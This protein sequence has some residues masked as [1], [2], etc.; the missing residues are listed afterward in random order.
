[1]VL[2][3]LESF[4]PDEILVPLLSWDHDLLCIP[5]WFPHEKQRY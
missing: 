2:Q 3:E 5:E 1:M 4:G